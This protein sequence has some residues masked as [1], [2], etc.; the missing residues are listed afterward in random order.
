[1]ERVLRFLLRCQFP[2]HWFYPP[3]RQVQMRPYPMN[4]IHSM[5][6]MEVLAK[7]ITLLIEKSTEDGLRQ[8]MAPSGLSATKR[9]TK[10][11]SGKKG[12]ATPVICTTID[13]LLNLSNKA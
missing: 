11:F 8:T 13:E 5:S 7:D 3:R 6:T 4:S 12:R 10:S 1:M 2:R 9:S